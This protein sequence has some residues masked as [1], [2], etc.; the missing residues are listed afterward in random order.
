M[1]MLRNGYIV[2]INLLKVGYVRS[3]PTF[4]LMTSFSFVYTTLFYSC[5]F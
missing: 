5:K 4:T 2:V 1:S 3:R